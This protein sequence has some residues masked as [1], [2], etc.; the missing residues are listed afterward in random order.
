M[1][2]TAN[3]G[4]SAPG[5][6][7]PRKTTPPSRARR[8]TAWW[9]RAWS[10]GGTLHRRWEELRTAPETGWHGMAH[11]IK[12][13]ISVAGA[14]ATVL[15][16]AAAVRV[17]DAVPDM[18]VGDDT[19]TGVWAVIDQPVRSYIT[20]HSTGLP[21]SASTVY[22]LWAA[23]GWACLILGCLTRSNGVRLTWTAWG[24]AGV[25]M[26]WSSTSAPGRTIATG[27]AVLAW[28]AASTFAL[29]G[30]NL[31]PR[32]FAHIHNAGPEIRPEIHIPAPTPPGDAPDNVH[33]L[34]RR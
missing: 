1:N 7:Q 34:N 14:S 12:A 11:W 17:L 26:V 19:S 10:D 16:A 24:A 30:L 29:R 3:T 5:T 23:T 25:A 15:L 6:G 27:I 32:V 2:P 18:G 21:I 22:T 28:T 33:P 31:R 9:N 4:N 8:I 13:L 20:T